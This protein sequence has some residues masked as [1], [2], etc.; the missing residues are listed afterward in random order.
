MLAARR[1]ISG[2]GGRGCANSRDTAYV[3]AYA[4][5][6]KASVPPCGY[7][8]RHPARSHGGGHVGAKPVAA[9]VLAG[10]ECVRVHDVAACRQVAALC[11]AI[12]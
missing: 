2:G 7:R 6:R 8:K 11:A 1:G 3:A 10:I 4:E 12:R 5:F 9:C